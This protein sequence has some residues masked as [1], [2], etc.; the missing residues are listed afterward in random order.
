MH[1]QF[2]WLKVLYMQMYQLHHHIKS[3]TKLFSNPNMKKGEINIKLNQVD[4]NFVLSI[5]DN[6]IG[7]PDDL[8]SQIPVH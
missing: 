8:V 3:I 1:F 5:S 7:I 6:G 4:E 2:Q